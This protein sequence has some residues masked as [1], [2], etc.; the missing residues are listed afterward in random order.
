MT[1]KEIKV[2][3]LLLMEVKEME[4]SFKELLLLKLNNE[5][6]EQK[7]LQRNTL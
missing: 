3:M 7:L 1:D 2:G 5:Q 6:M 4:N